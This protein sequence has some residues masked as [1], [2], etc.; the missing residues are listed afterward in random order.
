MVIIAKVNYF[1]IIIF[2][3]IFCIFAK[4]YHYEKHLYYHFNDDARFHGDGTKHQ[5]ATI[6]TR[7]V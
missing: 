6:D 3:S 7:R 5:T 2:C 1:A 4:N